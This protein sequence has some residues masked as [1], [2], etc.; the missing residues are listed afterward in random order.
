MATKSWAVVLVLFTTLLTS[1][2]QI[3]YKKASENLSV[4]P[5]QLITNYYLIGG[6]VLY[7]AGGIIMV[8]SLRGGEVSVLF[9]IIA[10]SY[11][12]VSFLSAFFL[13]ETMNSF[14]W[15]G[16]ITI[17]L[18]ISMIGYGSGR[19]ENTEKNALGVD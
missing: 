6:L 9:P 16:V 4:N 2:A 10:T 13:G 19:M 18:G 7:A 8:I 3:L 5:F 17:V 11:I 12:W 1:A 14:R 15:L